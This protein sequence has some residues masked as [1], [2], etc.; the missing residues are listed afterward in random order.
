MFFRMNP[1]NYK[2]IC[3][4]WLCTLSL[5]KTFYTFT[6]WFKNLIPEQKYSYVQ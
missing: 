6:F 4:F 3:R 5:P 2:H 1:M